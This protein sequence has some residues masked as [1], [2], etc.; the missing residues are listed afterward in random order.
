MNGRTRNTG[1]ARTPSS[2]HSQKR[3]LGKS[4]RKG[5]K[6]E[7]NAGYQRVA[8]SDESQTIT[9]TVSEIEEFPPAQSTLS[10]TMA[11]P[12]SQMSQEV[13]AMFPV[14]EQGLYERL[15]KL[16]SG[17]F[18]S[19][20]LVKDMRNNRLYAMKVLSLTDDKDGRRN[21]QE[22][23]LMRM[24]VHPTIVQLHDAFLTQDK[25]LLCLVMTYCESGDLAQQ[26]TEAKHKH[27]PIPEKHLLSWFAQ[28]F[29][30]I[31]YLHEH[32]LLH[33]DLKPQN[34]FLTES[35]KLIK[36][37]DLGLAK[38][39]T[40]EDEESFTECGTPYYTAP[41][42]INN[43]PY[44]L[45]S[46]VWSLG[47]CLYECLTMHLPFR[48]DNNLQLVK[49]I[50]SEDP[51]PIS[52]YYSQDV[53]CM[54]RWMLQKTPE[55]RPS[56]S[57]LLAT[58]CLMKHM[59]QF[60]KDYRPMHTEERQRRAQIK[61][62]NLQAQTISAT[63]KS[64]TVNEL[65]EILAQPDPEKVKAEQ[66][67][68]LDSQ[69]ES[70]NIPTDNTALP[71]DDVLTPLRTSEIN[72]LHEKKSIVAATMSLPSMSLPS[73]SLPPTLSGENPLAAMSWMSMPSCHEGGSF[74]D[75]GES[76]PADA[77][78]LTC[79]VDNVSV[80]SRNDEEADNVS[81]MSRNDEDGRKGSIETGIQSVT[82]PSDLFFEDGQA[83]QR[84]KSNLAECEVAQ[85][86]H[87]H[88]SIQDMGDER[89]LFLN[90][91]NGSISENETT[92]EE[93][94]KSSPRQYAKDDY[95]YN[96]IQE[97]RVLQNQDDEAH[98]KDIVN[99]F[100]QMTRKS[101]DLSTGHFRSSSADLTEI[102]KQL[103]SQEEN[104]ESH[105]LQQKKELRLS[106]QSLESLGASFSKKRL[107]NDESQN[108]KVSSRLMEA[109]EYAQDLEIA[110]SMDG[111]R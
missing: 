33:R 66:Q 32:H 13:E 79:D 1:G 111:C 8:S 107:S 38:I 97:N 110:S 88:V 58:P 29:L 25:K 21:L 61:D 18:G 9:S 104:G 14:E 53:R 55:R 74:F 44:S 39:L 3:T 65:N 100:D 15:R 34:L 67:S 22:V 82:S 37:G 96:S 7:Q 81:I 31:H 36:I 103:H 73:M 75:K 2:T 12:R 51:P 5:S 87:L 26:I 70:S 77:D 10:N 27:K 35:K 72:N 93:S 54:V 63:N 76:N 11:T 45:P 101:V 19:V 99:Q 30:G 28:V 50:T 109:L 17:A 71:D 90:E 68:S 47:V 83:F 85:P 62:M 60:I 48:G 40:R 80:M 6:G 16:G 91:D 59:I 102:H 98:I 86:I 95:I 52:E 43:Q 108:P 89:S 42:M 106:A 24:M 46:D 92:I 41:E 64:I 20:V 4:S 94:P 78:T 84:R 57:M 105:F 69:N 56:M 23:K 49:G